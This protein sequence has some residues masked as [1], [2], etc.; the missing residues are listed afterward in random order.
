M[1]CS[2]RW[3]RA[4]SA[5]GVTRW[6]RRAGT[7]AYPD[8]AHLAAIR[9]EARGSAPETDIL[10]DRHAN[11]LGFLKSLKAIGAHVP[12][13]GHRPASAARM[14]AALRAFETSGSAASY[15]IVTLHFRRPLETAA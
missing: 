15:E 8:V 5:N 1:C 4:H 13:P 10:V 7:P 14:R 3:H 9:P 12:A 2:I 11:A 6:N